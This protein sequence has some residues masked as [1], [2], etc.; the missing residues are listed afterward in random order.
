VIAGSTITSD[1]SP[2]SLFTEDEFR[3]RE[4]PSGLRHHAEGK[5]TGRDLTVDE[6]LAVGRAEEQRLGVSADE[7]LRTESATAPGTGVDEGELCITCGYWRA[8]VGPYCEAC[9]P[10][11]PLGAEAILHD[12]PAPALP[13]AYGSED[14]D[15]DRPFVPGDSRLS[16]LAPNASDGAGNEDIASAAAAFLQKKA[17]KVF[18]PAEQQMIIDEGS[19]EHLG[20]SNTDRLDLTG[21]FYELSTSGDDPIGFW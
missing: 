5:K 3:E 19:K 6:V 4:D 20:A 9:A 11:E 15:P 8:T 2:N 21:T 17:V 10:K 12:E 14:D 16:H 1:V 18:S 7:I 13:A